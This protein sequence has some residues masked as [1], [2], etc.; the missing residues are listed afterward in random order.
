MDTYRSYCLNSRQD[1]FAELDAETRQPDTTDIHYV[2]PANV[3]NP[4][5]WL[6]CATQTGHGCCQ[7]RIVTP[8]VAPLTTLDD[9]PKSKS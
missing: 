9:L 5:P 8:K 1:D 7:G 4:I 6:C 2:V 3:G